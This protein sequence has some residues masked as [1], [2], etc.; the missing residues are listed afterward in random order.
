M[1]T[2]FITLKRG[3]HKFKS[4][5]EGS[6]SEKWR[7]LPEQSL[8][9][10]TARE[11]VTFRLE[12][13]EDLNRPSWFFL[14][15]KLFRLEWLSLTFGPAF[16]TLAY[17]YKS[18]MEISPVS[19]GIG[20]SAI[21][22]FHAGVFALND[23]RDHIRGVDRLQINGGSQIIQRGW[24][25]AHQVKKIGLSLVATA[26]LL[27]SYLVLQQ[28]FFLIL[29]GAF[30]LLA[31]LG[32]SYFGK[33]LK[34]LGFGEFVAFFSFG[35]LLT[36][37]VARSISH[38]HSPE[39]LGLGFGFGYLAALIFYSKQIENMASD[40]QLGLRSFAL[41]L[42]FDRAKK[43]FEWLLIFTPFVFIFTI[44]FVVR[45]VFSY[46]LILPFCY[47][48]FKFYMKFHLITSVYSSGAEEL[49]FKL[50]DIHVLY[51]TLILLSVWTEVS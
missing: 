42:G 3:E 10:S 39:V 29:V 35:P 27:G 30:I 41:W 12:R 37:G 17:L 5:L 20:L 4:Y 31:V 47:F 21:F 6:F 38:F 44:A 49:R 40:S 2:Q 36:Y 1:E 15:F 16:A 7:A 51:S 34:Y 28:P 50:G 32:Y 23:Y 26:S 33:G 43:L 19:T 46:F 48:V 8:N 24:M 11:Q 13:V 14:L 9:I 45:G 22:L 25:A 18:G